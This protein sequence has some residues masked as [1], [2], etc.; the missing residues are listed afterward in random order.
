M[1]KPNEYRKTYVLST[2][3]P[4][5]NANASGKGPHCGEGT[6]YRG[7]VVWLEKDPQTADGGVQVPAYAEGV[8]VVLLACSSVQRAG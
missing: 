6:L 2:D 4:Y 3:V 5:A 7:R 1:T 8:G